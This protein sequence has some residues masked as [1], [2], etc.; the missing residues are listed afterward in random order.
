M[1]ESLKDKEELKIY[2]IASIASGKFDN[3]KIP[4]LVV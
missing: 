4:F 3:D 2:N 1:Y